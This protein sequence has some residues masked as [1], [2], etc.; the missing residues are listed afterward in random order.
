MML[1]KA[2]KKGSEFFLRTIPQKNNITL[3]EKS[4]MFFEKMS[5]YLLVKVFGEDI[6]NHEYEPEYIYTYT[7]D[8]DKDVKT[9][10]KIYDFEKFRKESTNGN[11]K[12][13]IK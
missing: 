12:R 2:I 1:F 9:I 7:I 11:V 5:D 8:L 3:K 4:Q 6:L 10:C 13:N